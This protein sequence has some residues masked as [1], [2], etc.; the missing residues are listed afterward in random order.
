MRVL[1][2][3]PEPAAKEAIDLFTF[4]IAK[5]IGALTASMGGLDGIVFTAGIGE[6]AP[7]I[8]AA[9][10]SRM[11]WTGLSLGA[12]ANARGAGLIS[13]PASRLRVW[14]IPTNEEAMIAR[15]TV[16][17]VGAQGRAG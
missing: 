2:A 16:E 14:V 3:S 13:A 12:E 7:E 1:L 10:A 6:N 9:V 17:R 5:E 11:A 8:R 4:R 15:H